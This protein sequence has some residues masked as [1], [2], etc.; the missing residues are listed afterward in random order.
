MRL[1]CLLSVLSEASVE[2]DPNL[3]V[4]NIE[5]DSRRIRPGDLFVAAPRHSVDGHRFVD[6]ALENGAYAVVLEKDRPL[7]SVTKI[8]VPNAR[9][10]LALMSSRLY[11]DPWRRF[12]RIVGITGTNG[13]TTVALLCSSVL[14]ASGMSTGLI[15]TIRYEVGG[16][17]RPASNTTPE[18]PD[19]HRLFAEMAE[20]GDRAAVLEVSSEGLALERTFGIG[21]DLAVF[22]TLGRDHLNFHG[23]MEAYLDAKAI[24]FEGLGETGR[25]VINRDDPAGATL[26]ERTKA[27]VL[28]YGFSKDAM[29]RAET[30]RG[31]LEGTVVEVHTPSGPL[32]AAFDLKGRFN[33]SN[34]LAAV[35]VGLAC[36]IDLET[37]GRGLRSVECV[38]GRLEPVACGQG[39]A[40]FVDY[41][42]TPDA[43]ETV[44]ETVKALSPGRLLSVF[45]CGGDRDR[46]KRP[47]MGEI[48]GRLADRTFVTSDNPRTEDPDAIVAEIVSGMRGARQYEVIPDRRAAIRAALMEARADDAVVI[49]GKGHEPYQ[50]IGTERIAFDDREVAREILKEIVEAESVD[51]M[52]DTHCG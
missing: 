24:L 39:F 27:S 46:G 17:T 43:L 29:I 44:L 22:T 16:A 34:A 2:G 14:K 37:I 42:H 49:A 10:A 8:R 50:I 41:A 33:V 20:A 6:H 40:V 11:G 52:S 28:T 45:G 25:A 5:Y 26:M 12:E 13:K 48:S 35:A 7:G 4:R 23:T 30:W 1:E 47:E 38:P 51:R 15:G 19:L 18:S 31:T 9:R 36:E 3:D 32:E 21:F